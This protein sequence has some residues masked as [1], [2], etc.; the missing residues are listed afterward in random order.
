MSVLP[1][2]LLMAFYSGICPAD[3]LPYKNAYNLSLHV[4]MRFHP[5][6]H[7]FV[8]TE[9]IKRLLDAKWLHV[10]CIGMA[11]LTRAV[12]KV[13][14][15]EI[16]YHL[17]DIEALAEKYMELTRGHW[18][19]ENS[20]HWILDVHFHEDASTANR[21]N[22]ISNLALPRKIAFN[23]TK[24]NPAMKKKTTKQKMID[25]MTDIQLFKKLVFEIIPA[26]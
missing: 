20:L 15:T 14:T 12:G 22:S 4:L 11:R 23:F 1:A 8:D 18:E 10:K 13:T 17:M 19:I 24:L 25:F 6:F 9:E 7:T 2:V 3:V 26:K 5:L 16:H 21:G